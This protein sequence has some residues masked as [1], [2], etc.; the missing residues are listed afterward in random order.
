MTY[1]IGWKQAYLKSFEDHED[2]DRVLREATFQE[3]TQLNMRLPL[4]ML[5]KLARQRTAN[6]TALLSLFAVVHAD[7]ND[8]VGDQPTIVALFI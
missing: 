6:A 2:L 7:D 5:S 8:G 1:S 4:A 3:N